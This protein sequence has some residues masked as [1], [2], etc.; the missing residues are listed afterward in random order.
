MAQRKKSAKKETPSI[1]AFSALQRTLNK[2]SGDIFSTLHANNLTVS[3]F[4]VLEALNKHGP[5]C[6][7]AL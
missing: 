2:V 3:Q 7:R 1:Q 6:Q 5:M 4:G